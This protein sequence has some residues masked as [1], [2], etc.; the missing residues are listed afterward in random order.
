MTG[1]TGEAEAETD[2][3]VVGDCRPSDE[4]S[5]NLVRSF[6]NGEGLGWGSAR[7]VSPDSKDCISRKPGEEDKC[8]GELH[9]G[10]SK[11]TPAPKGCTIKSGGVP[12]FESKR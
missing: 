12:G 8:E 9:A 11:L 1:S 2:K 3:S 7:A 5:D 4:R 10:I 6:P